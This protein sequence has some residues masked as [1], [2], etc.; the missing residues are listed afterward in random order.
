MGEELSACRMQQR[1][2]T[3]TYNFFICDYSSE[4]WRWIR[5]FTCEVSNLIFLFI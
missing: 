3:R 1:G 5:S 2:S 4:E